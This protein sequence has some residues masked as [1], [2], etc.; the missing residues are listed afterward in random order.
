M[1]TI[2]MKFDVPT[3]SSVAISNLL[4]A[5]GLVAMV[6]AVGGL[7]GVWWA[8]LAG[9]GVLVGLSIIGQTYAVKPATEQ[10][11][12]AASVAAVPRSA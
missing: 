3:P 7:A 5:L 4:G 12:A 2:K 1:A 8:V 9:G 6:L 10:K 11:P